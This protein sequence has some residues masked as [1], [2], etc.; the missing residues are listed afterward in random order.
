MSAGDWKEMLYAI[1]EGNED[2]VRY[3]ISEGINPDYQHPELL[4]APL[5]MSIE[6]RHINKFF[7]EVNKYKA[8][9]N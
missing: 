1:S 7:V 8:Y 9:V 5:I 6:S 3:H 2:L 4:T